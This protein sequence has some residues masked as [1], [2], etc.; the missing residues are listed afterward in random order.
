MVVIN[1]VISIS[2]HFNHF[3]LQQIFEQKFVIKIKY[4]KHPKN[5][6]ETHV[7]CVINM[8]VKIKKIKETHTCLYFKYCSMYINCLINLRA[9]TTLNIKHEIT[10]I[11]KK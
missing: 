1:L 8:K 2:N 3:L 9:I 7:P 4:Q 11:T 5:L 6:D 10:A